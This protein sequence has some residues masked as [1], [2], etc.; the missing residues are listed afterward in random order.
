MKGFKY[1]ALLALALGWGTVQALDN[2]LKLQTRVILPAGVATVADAANYFISPHQFKIM[3][4]GGAPSEAVMIANSPIPDTTPIGS[5][6]SVE[7]A[8]LS[9]LRQDQVLI[10]DT[11][12]RLISFGLLAKERTGQ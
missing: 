5:I 1:S 6:M 11:E 12:A 9:L 8:L 10:I 3:V 2:P 4:A 7:Q